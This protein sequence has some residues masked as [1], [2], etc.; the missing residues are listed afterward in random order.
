MRLSILAIVL[1]LAGCTA[2]PTQLADGSFMYS[3]G[4]LGTS[5]VINDAARVC[6]EQG[7]GMNHI[8][9]ECASVRC[10]SKFRCE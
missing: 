2:T 7:K 3:H 10:V 4:D 9:T 6:A 5:R 1:L 8:S